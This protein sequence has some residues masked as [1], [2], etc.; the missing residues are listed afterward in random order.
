MR[1][2]LRG[3]CKFFRR[4][5]K[6]TNNFEHSPKVKFQNHGH[7]DFAVIVCQNHLSKT[8]SKQNSFSFL[9]KGVRKLTN[10]TGPLFS[11]F[12]LFLR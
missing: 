4:V 6:L 5:I 12:L 9:N 1:V 3:S 8:L 10:L 2:Y 7:L 11:H